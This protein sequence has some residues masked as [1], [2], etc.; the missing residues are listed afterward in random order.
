MEKLIVLGTGNAMVTRCYNTCF[1]IFDS[2]EY[3]L[4]DGGGGNGILK[5]MED[6]RIPF[7]RVRNMFVS[8]AHTD[9]ILGVIWVIRKIATMLRQGKYKPPFTIY[10]YPEL[11]EA[12][13]TIATLT[14]VPAMV[15]QIDENNILFRPITDGETARIGPYG[16]TFFDIHSTK[17]KQFGFS[18]NL[19]NGSKLTFIGD[20]PYNKRCEHYVAGSRWLLSEAF[21]LYAERERFKP[22]EKHHATV[23]DACEL[24]QSLNVE[25]LVLWHT[26]DSNI[27]HRKELYT[28]EG[29]AYYTGNLFVPDDLDVIEF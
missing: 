21:C 26:E 24:A 20:E 13:R 9:H 10:C 8:H 7:E 28:I 19:M 6:A 17:Q 1:A 3:F 2:E 16:T 11:A 25:N 27:A 22:Y 23:K 4:V 29:S 14:L 15:K 5:Q 12:I 18:L